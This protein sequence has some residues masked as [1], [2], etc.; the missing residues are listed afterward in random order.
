MTNH[1]KASIWARARQ[2]S[3]TFHAHQYTPYDL[4]VW[5]Y[6]RRLAIGDAFAVDSR[7]FSLPLTA[8]GFGSRLSCSFDHRFCGGRVGRQQIGDRCAED[9][10]RK[11][12]NTCVCD[13][14]CVVHLTELSVFKLMESTES[15][16][17]WRKLLNRCRAFRRA[18]IVK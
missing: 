9:L 7:Q 11:Q 4:T 8:A 14:Q 17:Q 13:C 3:G 6:E 18:R 16:V 10:P 12:Q 5:V 1:S 2:V 15:V